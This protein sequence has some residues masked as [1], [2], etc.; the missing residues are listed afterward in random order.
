[1]S[2]TTEA[3][4][5]LDDFAYA[6]KK[7]EAEGIAW[8]DADPEEQKRLLNE[9]VSYNDPVLNPEDAHLSKCD[10]C[11][12]HVGI[13]TYDDNWAFTPEE[14]RMPVEHICLWCAPKVSIGHI[15]QPLFKEVVRQRAADIKAGFA[16]KEYP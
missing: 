14:D 7:G 9:A 1:M 15:G 6:L 12:E 3:I 8:A 5:T 13:G 4:Y 10:R 16:P 2:E 11:E